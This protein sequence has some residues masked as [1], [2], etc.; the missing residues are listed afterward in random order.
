M[1]SSRFGEPVPGAGHLAGG[2][3]GDQRAR[4]LRRR[5]RRVGLQVDGGR[6]RD[7][8]RRHRRA[9]DRVGGRVA[10]VPRRRDARARREDVQAGAVVRERGARVGAGR[11]ADGDRA[12]RARRRGVARV[13][14]VVAGRERVGDAVGD[15]VASRPSS[16][17]LRRAAAEAHVGHGGLAGLV[18][19]G[20]PVRR[21]RSRREL[22]PRAGAVEHAHG[23]ERARPWPRRRCVPPTVPATCVPWPLQSS[24]RAAV[25][26]VVAADVARPPKSLCVEADA[27]VDDVRRHARARVRRS[28]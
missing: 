9:A 14:V 27:G 2:G 5:R 17:A 3:R 16:S 26:R 7:V 23:D 18:V 8:R 11:R 22:V 21:P 24:A 15:R 4:D 25:D 1:Y 12:R 13:G 20:D 10:R 28:V 6:A 19:A